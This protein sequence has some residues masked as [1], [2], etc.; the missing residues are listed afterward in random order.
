ML[1]NIIA[2]NILLILQKMKFVFF[3]IRNKKIEKNE[4]TVLTIIK[5]TIKSLSI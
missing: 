3:F 5:I 1:Q 2:N 4:I